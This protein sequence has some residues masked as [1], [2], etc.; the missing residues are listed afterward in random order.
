MEHSPTFVLT[1][2]RLPREQAG[3]RGAHG[4]A[5]NHFAIAAK[6]FEFSSDMNFFSTLHGPSHPHG[7]HRLSGYRST[8]PRNSRNGDSDLCIRLSQRTQCHG[9]RDSLADGTVPRERCAR[10]VETARLRFIAVSHETRSEPL[11]TSGDIRQDFRDPPAG[12]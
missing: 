9:A 2:R 7:A 5:S 4:L 6:V 1:T 3:N 8:R 12:T 11:R 10:H